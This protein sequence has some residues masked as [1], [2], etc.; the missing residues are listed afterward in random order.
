MGKE[1]LAI[2]S[3]I[4]CFLHSHQNEM[5]IDFK[6]ESNAGDWNKDEKKEWIDKWVG[7]IRE[8]LEFSDTRTVEKILKRLVAT[9]ESQPCCNQD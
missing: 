7:I 8:E 5:W 3:Q 6:K 4:N 2:F 9:M 1:E